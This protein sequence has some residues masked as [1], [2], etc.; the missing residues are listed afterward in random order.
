MSS[1]TEIRLGKAL[2]GWFSFLALAALFIPGVVIARALFFPP[3]QHEIQA[4]LDR[5]VS[6]AESDFLPVRCPLTW[7]LRVTEK[8]EKTCVMEATNH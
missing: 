4:H 2:F 5:M 3:S 8:G 1:A 7:R 6:E